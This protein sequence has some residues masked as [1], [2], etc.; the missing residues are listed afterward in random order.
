LSEG[1]TD[2][3]IH[4]L[5]QLPG[6][7][8]MA[9]STVFRYRGQ[10]VDA[11]EVGRAL[12]VR[13]VL[14]GRVLQRGNT[15]QIG[16]ELV[17]VQDGS[18]LWGEQYRRKLT[19]VLAVQDEI[20][21]EIAEKL[22]LK[23][24]V[25]QRNRLVKRY[26][27]NTEAYQFYLKG[28]YYW[29]KRTAKGL[30]QGIRN[31]RQAIDTDPGYALAYAGLADCYSNLGT[32]GVRAPLDVFPKAKAAALKALAIDDAMAEAHASLAFVLH[33]FDWDWPGA[34][35]EFKKALRLN[36]SCA[37]AQHWY[38]WYLMRVGRLAEGMTALKRA[39]ELD[40]L[41]LPITTSVG[42]ALYYAHR[43][44]EAIT[45]FNKALDLEP[46]FAEAR[47]SLA[48][49]YLEK[50]MFPEAIAEYR[51]ARS[52]C[53]GSSAPLAHLGHA[54]AV[55]GRRAKAEKVLA[56]L[57]RRSPG[58]YVSSYD[59]ATIHFALGD[60]AKGFDRLE[61]AAD[62]RSYFLIEILHDP[63]VDRFRSRARFKSVLRRMNLSQ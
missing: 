40:V 41:S 50:R 46:D 51:K 61:R 9:R 13:A 54:F 38:G 52:L 19:D 20:A 17:D 7:R 8:V 25:G 26:T 28:R 48:D 59:V 15:L 49:A 43:Y 16:A 5:S 34:E 10:T 18:R 53:K 27:E 58:E 32:Y 36:S 21:T 39:H 3:L 45:A 12:G 1:I 44:D 37:N 29:N 4:S 33:L 11:Q 47:R 6:L 57:Q 56:A 2:S 60:E 42:N 23:L 35:E 31:F 63:K 62:E 24:S 55:A 22:R 14:T 30:N